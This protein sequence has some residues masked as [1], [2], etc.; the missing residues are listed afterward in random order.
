MRFRNEIAPVIGRST[1]ATGNGSSDEHPNTTH[2]ATVKRLGQQLVEAYTAGDREAA[3]KHQ[4][5]M[6]EAIR[7]QAPAS[8]ARRFAEIDQAIAR[9]AGCYFVERGDAERTAMGGVA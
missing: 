1:R 2:L 4:S 6:L 9:S 7:Q 8:Q 5:A 3:I